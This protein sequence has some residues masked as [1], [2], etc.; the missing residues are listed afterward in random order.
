MDY[1]PPG[2]SV[3]GILHARTLEQLTIPCSRGSAQSRIKPRSPTS[4]EDSLQSEPRGKPTM[5]MSLSKFQERVKDREGRCV[6]VHRVSKSWTRCSDWTTILYVYMYAH[7]HTYIHI[8]I[9]I[10]SN[11]MSVNI[12]SLSQKYQMKVTIQL[13]QKEIFWVITNT[14]THNILRQ[15]LSCPWK[16]RATQI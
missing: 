4:E 3:H 6:V 12:I 10:F 7:T 9:C 11:S 15:K 1:S 8:S 16:Y 14:N 5:D 2:S 13:W